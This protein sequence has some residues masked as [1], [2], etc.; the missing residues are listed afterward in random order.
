MQHEFS[1]VSNANITYQLSDTMGPQ[2]VFAHEKGMYS[3][4]TRMFVDPLVSSQVTDVIPTW[5]P[6]T[7]FQT[8]V[9]WL[10]IDQFEVYTW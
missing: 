8:V 9:L 6:E 1:T 2:V 7:I 5:P 4:E 3:C 10:A